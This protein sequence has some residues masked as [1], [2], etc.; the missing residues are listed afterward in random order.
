VKLNKKYDSL[1]RIHKGLSINILWG[2]T[3]VLVFNCILSAYCT[4]AVAQ[5]T[6]APPQ[7][8]PIVLQG[9]TLHAGNGTPP[10]ENAVIIFVDGKI[11]YAG[12]AAG[13]PANPPNAEIMTTAGKHLYPGIIAPNTRL[14]LNE[15][16]SVRGTRDQSETGVL[17]PSAR[18]IIAYNVDSRVTPT[19][20]SNGILVA[21]IAPVGVRFAGISSIVQLDA[22]NW[23]DAIVAADNGLHLYWPSLRVYDAPPDE[24]NKQLEAQQKAVTEIHDFLTAA[25]S[26][27]QTAPTVKNQHYEALIPVFEGKRKLFLH[28]ET[29]KELQSALAVLT[30]L[31]IKPV[32]VGIKEPQ[33]CL[34]AIKAAGVPVILPPLHSLPLYEDDP[35]ASPFELATVLQKNNILFC[36]SL[37]GFWQQRNLS[38]QAG[39]ARA[40]GLSYEQALRSITLSTAEIL[41]I[42]DRTGSIEA[43]KDA[44]IIVAKGDIL[45]MRTAEVEMAFIQ[46]RKIN[47]DNAQKTLYRKYQDKYNR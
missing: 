45:D 46:G 11:R 30:P 42:A 8:T 20:R 40:F 24:L 44:T 31:Q 7:K 18:A 10:I 19:I 22:W 26:Y 39:T 1:I 17:N 36:L 41:G 32:L 16:E 14:G 13:A 2:F 5:L 43:G 29:C 6:P 38:F 34:E 4:I 9:G 27:A 15:I 25:L 21:Q 12:A 3:G 23:E 37:E 35:I 47:L 28:L 33:W